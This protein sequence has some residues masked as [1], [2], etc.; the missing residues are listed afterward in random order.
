[1]QGK[2]LVLS[3]SRERQGLVTPAISW[4]VLI[5]HSLKLALLSKLALPSSELPTY[6]LTWILVWFLE[7]VFAIANPCSNFHLLS[8]S[9]CLW[10]FPGDGSRLEEETDGNG[11]H[12]HVGKTHWC[13][14]TRPC[15]H[16]AT[17]PTSEHSLLFG[18]DMRIPYGT[19]YESAP[20][21]VY[22][23]R[24]EASNISRRPSNISLSPA[25]CY[26]YSFTNMDAVAKYKNKVRL[27]R[28]PNQGFGLVARSLVQKLQDLVLASAV[29]KNL[30][31]LSS[32][33]SI[34]AFPLLFT[35]LQYLSSQ[36]KAKMTMRYVRAIFRI[37]HYR[38]VNHMTPYNRTIVATTKTTTVKPLVFATKA[39]APIIK[40]AIGLATKPTFL[41]LD[42]K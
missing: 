27:F 5:R 17:S 6:S 13:T 18:H 22:H 15:M 10:K 8:T 40:S 14:H 26:F 7:P 42:S 19:Q 28:S 31:L 34:S 36:L 37:C 38:L 1:M 23:G 21:R 24:T 35:I 16:H 2:S 33:F 4:P 32:K 20:G 25:A 3:L 12:F 29:D 41:N 11:S 9:R 30:A 39:K